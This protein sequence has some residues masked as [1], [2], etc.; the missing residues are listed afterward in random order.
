MMSDSGNENGIATKAVLTFCG[1]RE[2]Y[3]AWLPKFTAF[4]TIHGLLHVITAA[5]KG[6][7]PASED[8][9]SQ[10][11]EQQAAV[12]QNTMVV[13]YLGIAIDSA[14]LIRKIEKMKTAEWP[15]NL[16]FEII[17]MLNKKFRPNDLLAL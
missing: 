16:A 2:K 12:K 14:A 3:G 6:M 4:L 9:G 7:L 10:T 5:F 15:N 1:A 13:G 17:E 8:A 11:R